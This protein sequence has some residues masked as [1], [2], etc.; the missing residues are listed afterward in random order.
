LADSAEFA[1]PRFLVFSVGSDQGGVEFVGDECLEFGSGEAQCSPGG[2]NRKSEVPAENGVKTV[3]RFD[4]LETDFE[5]EQT[6][7]QPF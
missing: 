7:D 4:R 6:S 1:E 3:C 5:F 2:D